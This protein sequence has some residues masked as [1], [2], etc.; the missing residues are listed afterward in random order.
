MTT[1]KGFTRLR[2]SW[3]VKHWPDP[4][5]FG[6]PQYWAREEWFA[7]LCNRYR[8]ENDHLASDSEIFQAFCSLRYKTKKQDISLR[9]PTD[10][11]RKKKFSRPDVTPSQKRVIYALYKAHKLGLDRYAMDPKLDWDLTAFNRETQAGWGTR[12]FWRVLYY[13]SK[14][15]PN[16]PS[17]GRFKSKKPV[18]KLRSFGDLP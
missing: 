9:C 14:R 1:L 4:R 15:D 13:L 3:L 7:A 16:F 17:K 18:S 6:S 5:K 12:D 2:R 8:Q 10:S 11:S